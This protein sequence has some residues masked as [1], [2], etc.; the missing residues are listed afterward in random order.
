MALFS[1]GGLT[2]KF[3]PVPYG[4]LHRIAVICIL[5]WL[6]VV[7]LRQMLR[8]RKLPVSGKK[9]ELVSRLLASNTL[10]Q[11]SVASSSSHTHLEPEISADKVWLNSCS[12]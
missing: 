2:A 9:A 7:D 6:Q 5:T 11:P 12:L 4:K 3:L 8:E 10:D 1:G